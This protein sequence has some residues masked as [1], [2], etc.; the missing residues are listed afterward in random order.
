MADSAWLFDVSC[1]GGC[2]RTV[3][4]SR[5]GLCRSCWQARQPVSPRN[6]K[7]P[8]TAGCGRMVRHGTRSGTCRACWIEKFNSD[9][10]VRERRTAGVRRYHR[11]PAT[12]ERRSE[13]ARRVAASRMR[14]PFYVALLRKIMREVAQPLSYTPENLARRDEKARGIAVSATKLSWCPPAYREHYRHLVNSKHMPSAEARRMILE[15][16]ERDEQRLGPD[17]LSRAINRQVTAYARDNALTLP[18]ANAR[19][20][21]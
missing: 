14:N 4:V 3:K 17:E 19:L 11:D 12:A 21:G 9:A 20:L 1:K 5:T 7:Q 13:V 10:A 18:E 2:G 15:L 8:C 16:V 6:F